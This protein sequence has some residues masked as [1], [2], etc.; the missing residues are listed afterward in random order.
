MVSPT[1]TVLGWVFV[2]V[3]QG[4]VS[5]LP[6][7]FFGRKR[8]PEIGKLRSTFSLKKCE[9]PGY[10][11]YSMFFWIGLTG[12]GFIGEVGGEGGVPFSLLKTGHMRHCCHRWSTTVL[13]NCIASCSHT[14][15]RAIFFPWCKRGPL[16][17]MLLVPCVECE[18]KTR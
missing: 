13:A 12:S 16:L 4:L 6:P 9:S 10:V 5:K 3:V 1:F 18:L 14:S 8:T 2:H 15:L 17:D 7:S 11:F